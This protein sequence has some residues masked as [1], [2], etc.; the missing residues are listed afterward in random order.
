M[1]AAAEHLPDI[2]EILAEKAE[3]EQENE[4]L[5]QEV[6]ALK[7]KLFGKQSE[8]LAKLHPGQLSLFEEQ[9]AELEKLVQPTE[10]GMETE[11]MKG[12]PK[13]RK[14]LPEGLEVRTTELHPE[15]DLSQMERIGQE[16]TQVLD[17][18]PGHFFIV[19]TI[20]HKYKDPAG[21]IQ[22][23][24][25]AE[26]PL[27]KSIAGTGLL[28]NILVN[29]YVDHL[30]FY[31]QRQRFLQQGVNLS[32]ASMSDWAMGCAE[33]LSPLY[34]LI[35]QQ[36]HGSGYIEVD[37][38]II[39]VFEKKEDVKK[40]MF[41]G[42]YWVCYSPQSRDV[43]FHFAPGRGK[44]VP[45]ELFR[46]FS[47]YLQSD[48]YKAYDHLPGLY[49]EITPLCCMAHARRYFHQL[50]DNNDKAR[51]VVEQ[52][53]RLYQIESYLR[54]HGC[55]HKKRKEIRQEKA[56]PILDELH[57]WMQQHYDTSKPK[58][59]L[60][61]AIGY[62]ITRWEKLT[63]YIEDG[64]LEIDN[65]LVENAIRPVA[66]GR[67]NYLFAGS[68]LAAKNA[69]IFYTLFTNCKIHGIDPY[70]WLRDVLDRIA[71]HPINRIEE[72]LPQKWKE[73][74]LKQE[75]NS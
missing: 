12:T 9:L 69:G 53:A 75:E 52:M 64:K 74:K 54:E 40:R 7:R 60:K 5:R 57:K 43:C 22:I 71:S 59:K 8:K 18:E 11:K 21:H 34:Q 67:K 30:P 4:R 55:S 13:R 26:R 32:A 37:E 38:T 28:T 2:E 48:G 44:Q 25:L 56:K 73:A 24:P 6:A 68:Q 50:A 58:S 61:E 10:A 39:K 29:K 41:Q 19:Q 33:L 72:L 1:L 42:Y 20:R 45:Q 63:R 70:E 16:M 17:Y 27:P 15:G 62:A 46:E 49:P 65:N 3:L 36:I 66:L 35:W 51:H 31:R 47:G 14:T 23:A